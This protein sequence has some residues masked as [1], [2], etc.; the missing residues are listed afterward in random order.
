MIDQWA[1][2]EERAARQYLTSSAEHDEN[3]HL[4]MKRTR[5]N[6]VR[7]VRKFFRSLD[8]GKTEDE[9]TENEG[10]TPAKQ[11]DRVCVTLLAIKS[12]FVCNFYILKRLLFI[13]QIIKLSKKSG[14]TLRHNLQ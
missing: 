8:G 6:I 11:A 12:S 2:N 3:H 5:R 4:V 13:K 1:G 10:D 9:F 7:P 14:F